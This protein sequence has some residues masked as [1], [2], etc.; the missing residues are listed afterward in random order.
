MKINAITSPFFNIFLPKDRA[1]DFKV[2]IPFYQRP[3]VWKPVNV[4]KLFSDLRDDLVH[5][6]GEYESGSGYFAGPVVYI[7]RKNS[8]SVID[9]EMVDGQQR[10][11]SLFFLLYLNFKRLAT[12]VDKEKNNEYWWKELRE[13]ANFI[14]LDS[15]IEMYIS[16]SKKDASVEFL[17]CIANSKM[18][19]ENSTKCYRL[20]KNNIKLVYERQDLNN[21]LAFA[22][23]S[24]HLV[25]FQDSN[26]RQ[27]IINYTIK[28]AQEIDD[29]QINS[30]DSLEKSDYNHE[31]SLLPDFDNQ[32]WTID[33]ALDWADSTQNKSDDRLQVIR[34]IEG[35]YLVYWASILL[36]ESCDNLF[37][38]SNDSTKSALN[39]LQLCHLSTERQDDA[40]IL[41]EVLNNTGIGL[42]NMD[43]IKN[44]FYR[45]TEDIKEISKENS[46]VV[47]NIDKKWNRCLYSNVDKY[48]NKPTQFLSFSFLS[49]DYRLDNKV[50]NS[51]RKTIRSLE[52]SLLKKSSYKLEHLDEDLRIIKIV[53]DILKKSLAGNKITQHS[54]VTI[55]TA[56]SWFCRALTLLDSLGQTGVIPL[57]FSPILSI[58]I[59]EDNEAVSDIITAILNNEPKSNCISR[60]DLDK[61]EKFSYNIALSCLFNDTLTLR[62]V[63]NGITPSP[64]LR[65]STQNVDSDDNDFYFT[66]DLR[67]NRF[68]I[69]LRIESLTSFINT[70][71]LNIPDAYESLS[72]KISKWSYKNHRAKYLLSILNIIEPTHKN[73]FDCNCKDYSKCEHIDFNFI[74]NLNPSKWGRDLQEDHIEPQNPNSNYSS[75]RYYQ[76]EDRDKRI[77]GVHNIFVTVAKDNI[78][79]SNHPVMGVPIKDWNYETNNA[80]SI[81]INTLQYVELLSSFKKIAEMSHDR[82]DYNDQ[83]IE[84][85]LQRLRNLVRISHKLINFDITKKS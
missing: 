3:Y 85:S 23:A 8:Q 62:N 60:A 63:V 4:F 7:L 78:K 40:F 29:I 15:F 58:I 49:G 5:N 64:F 1:K 20:I 54:I 56:K 57:L 83:Y 61:I 16:E 36:K 74:D 51:P 21:L 55:Y 26:I 46:S 22:L 24:F 30:E 79:K 73:N 50:Q 14:F 37:S 70:S 53:R 18:D 82:T 13:K 52:K 48:L 38:N 65:N 67:C 68:E 17:K 45:H 43:L 47:A 6:K 69:F 76:G 19:V 66:K 35:I 41:F 33:T 80:K 2:V 75:N 59:R 27:S 42:S 44:T 39:S 77:D 81:D 71:L 10:S 11:T 72:K 28:F 34:Y 32:T 9:S 31:V 12:K 84:F 25:K